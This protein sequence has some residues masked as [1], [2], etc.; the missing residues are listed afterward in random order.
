MPR[1]GGGWGVGVPGPY[2]L[3]LSPEGRE[4]VR[5]IYPWHDSR[6]SGC[7]WNQTPS[8]YHRLRTSS[9][10]SLLWSRLISG[11]SARDVD[12]SEEGHGY[13]KKKINKKKDKK[14]IRETRADWE[15]V[16]VLLFIYFLEYGFISHT[17]LWALIAVWLEFPPVFFPK[18]STK[19][20]ISHS[21]G[22]SLIL[23]NTPV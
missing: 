14:E 2:W 5:V 11:E 21:L 10:A 7:G 22:F 23:T 6:T 12:P 3:A 4:F 15:I 17:C 8:S 9:S 1:G 18:K 19:H 16:L 20:D 13:S